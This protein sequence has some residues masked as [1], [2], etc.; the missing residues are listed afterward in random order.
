MKSKLLRMNAGKRL[1][2]G[3]SICAIT[4]LSL[5]A[6][7]K[8]DLIVKPANNHPGKN[9]NETEVDPQ[10]PP[11]TLDCGGFRTQTQGGWGAPAHGNNPGKYMQTNFA[12]A[13]PNGLTV[14]CNNTLTLTSAQ[15]VTDYLPAGGTPAVLKTSYTNP[16][17]LKNNLASQ[18]VTLTLSV[19]FDLYD[20]NFSS[21]SI[22]LGDLVIASGTFKGMSIKD[23]LAEANKVLG[24]CSSSYTAAQVS[25]ALTSINENFDDGTKNGGFLECPD[26]IIVIS[27]TSI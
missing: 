24:G 23:F 1:I 20:P 14:G 9:H 25:D 2:Q 7:T 4:L 12:G 8:E 3:I 27:K 21:S 6:C 15:A 11:D 17:T 26:K 13:F 10:L 19:Q 16:T 22:Q 18:L 5:N